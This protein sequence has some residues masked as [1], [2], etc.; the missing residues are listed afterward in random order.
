M[1][2]YLT[3]SYL[4]SFWLPSVGGFLAVQTEDSQLYEK[5]LFSASQEGK[6]VLATEIY[7]GRIGQDNFFFTV[8]VNLQNF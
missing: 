1:N 7:S 4:P 2:S 8:Y 6:G 3:L 5:G